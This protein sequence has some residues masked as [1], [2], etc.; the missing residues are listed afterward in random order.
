VPKPEV[1]K[2]KSHLGSLFAQSKDRSMSNRFTKEV[3]DHI[4][5]VTSDEMPKNA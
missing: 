2:R 3:K 4:Q 1:Q 5:I